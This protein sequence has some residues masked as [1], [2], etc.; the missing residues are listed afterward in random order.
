MMLLRCFL[1]L[2]S[3]LILSACAV[4]SV[5][6]P[7]AQNVM[8]FD[9][10]KQI[11]ANGYLGVNTYQLQ[12]AHNPTKHFLF[13]LNNSYGTGLAIYE[14]FIGFYNYQKKDEP[15]WRHEVLAGGGYTNNFSQVEHG[16]FAALQN[17]NSNFETISVYNKFFLQPSVGFFSKIK[18]YKLSYSFSLSTRVSYL[19]FKKYIYREIDADHSLFNGSTNYIVNK[20]YYNK[21]L[22]LFEPCI[23][24]KVG[25][26]NLYVVLQLLTITPYSSEIDIRYTKFSPVFLFSLGI[27][28]NLIFKKRGEQKQ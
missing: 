20:E 6:V 23:T 26:R 22:F 4:R 9:N 28:Y 13:G 8:L 24:N 14:G 3:L 21:N 10:R 15:K 17:R 18:M 5:Y 27:Q 16:W 2:C 7:A 25:L 11:Q 1:V 19:D 12:L